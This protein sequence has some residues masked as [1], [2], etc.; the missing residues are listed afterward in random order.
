MARGA[1]LVKRQVSLGAR[2]PSSWPISVASPAVS[3]SWKL[4]AH[5]GRGVCRGQKITRETAKACH[6][7]LAPPQDRLRISVCTQGRSVAGGMQGHHG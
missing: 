3:K 1:H 5:G 6:P 4:G 7:P 2:L